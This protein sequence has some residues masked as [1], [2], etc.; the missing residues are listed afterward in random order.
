ML[1]FIFS[2]IQS[3]SEIIIVEKKKNKKISDVM[4]YLY[5]ILKIPKN[6]K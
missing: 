4:N 3:F 6:H 5:I 1:F 2:E